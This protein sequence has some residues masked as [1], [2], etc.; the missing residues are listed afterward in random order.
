MRRVH[1]PPPLAQAL[2]A[3][4]VHVV[5]YCVDGARSSL[6]SLA[7]LQVGYPRISPHYRSFEDWSADPNLP[8]VR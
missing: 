6:L 5:P 8:V 1:P 7:L 2:F 4:R 3:R